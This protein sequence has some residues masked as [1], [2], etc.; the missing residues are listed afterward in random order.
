MDHASVNGTYERYHV[1]ISTKT[2][3]KVKP[4]DSL[5]KI[6]KEYFGD[7]TKWYKIFEANKINM[8][9]PNSLYVGQLDKN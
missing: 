7:E 1:D 2:I 4:N 5:S 6:A 8:S 3:Y 9:D